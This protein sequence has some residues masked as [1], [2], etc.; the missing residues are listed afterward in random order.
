MVDPSIFFY[1]SQFIQ[2]FSLCSAVVINGSLGKSFEEK[3][4]ICTTFEKLP[5]SPKE[6]ENG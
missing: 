5:L 3:V 4:G 2:R 1:Y 6:L